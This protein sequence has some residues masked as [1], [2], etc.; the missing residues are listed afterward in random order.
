MGV[1]AG[2]RHSMQD[3]LPGRWMGLG[4]DGRRGREDRKRNRKKL[5]STYQEGQGEMKRTKT[6]WNLHVKK[7]LSLA[8]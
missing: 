2:H 8:D 6:T 4:K 7:G 5:D 3:W 1:K